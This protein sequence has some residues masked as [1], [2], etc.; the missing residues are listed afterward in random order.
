MSPPYRS[1]AQGD[2]GSVE[3][4]THVACWNAQTQ[5]R[6]SSLDPSARMAAASITIPGRRRLLSLETCVN[7]QH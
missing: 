3:T 6:F 2:V 5:P 1:L 4:G 7:E